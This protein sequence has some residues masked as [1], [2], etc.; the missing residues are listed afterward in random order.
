MFDNHLFHLFNLIEIGLRLILII[1]LQSLFVVYAAPKPAV[2]I[3]VRFR[4]AARHV[5][6]RPAYTRKLFDGTDS[7]GVPK[8]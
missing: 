2:Q 6:V 5:V 8:E 3:L 1:S 4:R 7:G